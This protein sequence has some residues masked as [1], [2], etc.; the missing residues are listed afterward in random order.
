MGFSTIHSFRHPLGGL[1]TYPP[2]TEWDYCIVFIRFYIKVVLAWGTWVAQSV[3]HP[4]ID[5]SSGHDLTVCEMEPH[6]RLCT[7]SVESA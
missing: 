3:R 7:D 5:F 2:W 6:I 1:G 4:T